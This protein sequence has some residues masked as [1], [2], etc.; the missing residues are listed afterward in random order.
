MKT[1]WRRS[2]A[3][4]A[5][6][7]LTARTPK[8]VTAFIGTTL[9]HDA[10]QRRDGPDAVGR[11]DGENVHSF[12][13]SEGTRQVGGVRLLEGA[14]LLLGQVHV[15]RRDC[16]GQVMRLGWSHDGSGHDRVLQHPGERD[17]RHRDP[18]G[19][20][21]LPDRVDDGLVALD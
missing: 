9:V 5:I 13:C 6:M 11:L 7:K 20:R 16:V 18:P 4:M 2:S 12:W 19:L 14:D 21:D 3:Y 1:L 15:E 10:A 8:R 17:V